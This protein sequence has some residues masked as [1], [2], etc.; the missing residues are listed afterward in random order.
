MIEL[1]EG[2]PAPVLAV[3]ARERVTA[4]DYS[5]VLGPACDR[6]VATHGAIRLLYYLGPDFTRFT[7][8]ALWD[9]S[10]LGFHHLPD[11]ERVA[12]VTDVDWLRNLARVTDA[13][14]SAEVRAF[15]DGELAEAG[16]WIREGLA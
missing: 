6:L 9:D 14:L 11:V 16:A 15:T 8:T 12:V 3:R 1:L 2:F 7:T 10:R 13:A 4:E 5:D